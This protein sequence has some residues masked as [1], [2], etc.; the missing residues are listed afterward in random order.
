M[1]TR[2]GQTENLEVSRFRNG[3]AIPQAKTEEEWKRLS[4][5]ERK[6]AWCYYAFDETNGKK[7]GKLYNWFAVNDARGLAPSGWHVP[8]KNEFAELIAFA[9]GDSFAGP[10]L[11]GKSGWLNNRNGTDN[12]GFNLLPGGVMGISKIYNDNMYG[13]I[14]KNAKMWTSSGESE[15]NAVNIIE[16][17]K[18]F[19]ISDYSKTEGYSVR[20]IKD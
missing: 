10:K 20:L 18:Y 7:Y 16:N 17:E 11:R 5:V 6:P 3:D 19:Y 13:N 1:E 9:G 8:S 12:F 2:Y 15:Y 4:D 14:G